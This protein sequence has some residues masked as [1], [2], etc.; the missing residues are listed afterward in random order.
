MLQLIMRNCLKATSGWHKQ[1]QYHP[2][3]KLGQK[4]KTERQALNPEAE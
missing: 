4:V 1:Q 3:A 2:D